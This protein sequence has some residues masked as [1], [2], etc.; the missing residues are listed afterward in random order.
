MSV[1]KQQARL[2]TLV[3]TSFFSSFG[4]ALA[5]MFSCSLGTSFNC[6]S[7]MLFSLPAV[8]WSLSD[9]IS[10]HL[11]QIRLVLSVTASSRDYKT[12]ISRVV[13][14]C[15]FYLTVFTTLSGYLMVWNMF[16]ILYLHSMWRNTH[17]LKKQTK[18]K[19]NFTWTHP[20][21][22]QSVSAAWRPVVLFGSRIEQEELYGAELQEP[23]PP[24]WLLT[25]L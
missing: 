21:W 7:K 11:P 4:L 9:L 13:R 23:R 8:I 5:G 18:K 22:G 24:D 2:R 16:W 6:I 3:K 25:C 12:Q 15:F 19:T 10:S 1:R 20:V 14:K 17:P